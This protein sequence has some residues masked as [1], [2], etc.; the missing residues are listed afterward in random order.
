M[1]FSLALFS[2]A[3]SEAIAQTIPLKTLAAGVGRYFG[4]EIGQ[5]ALSDTNLTALT[6]AQC[7]VTTPENEMKWDATEP[8]QGVFTFTAGDAIV[9]FAEANGISVRGHNLVWSS[10]LPSCKQYFTRVTSTNWTNATLI[11]AMTNHITNVVTHYKGK[12]I[13]WD[14]VNEPF[15][16]DG[17]YVSDVFYNTIGPEYIPIALQAAR[18]ADPTVKLFIN[19]YNLDY[20][21]AKLT[22]MVN[23]VTSLHARGIPIDGIG[24]ESHLIVGNVS[25]SGYASTIAQMAAA[26]PGVLVAITEL[27]IRMPTPATTANLN[28]QETDYYSVVSACVQYSA[29]IGVETWGI[30]DK[31]SWIPS[32][33][34]GYGAALPYD[35]NFVPK[36]A[37]TG[38]V[39]GFGSVSATSS[40]TTTTTTTTA[41]TKT[42]TT[43]TTTTTTATTTKTTTVIT[44]TTTSPTTTTTTTTT[45]NP[46]TTTTTTITTAPTT[47]TATTGGSCSVKWGQCGGILWTGPTC[48]IAS[49]CTPQAGNPYYSQCL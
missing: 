24:S 10:Q 8:T 41:T 21:S 33:F 25:P 23:L 31:Y 34:S 44:T 26:F 29:C 27:D 47:T 45:K 5:E 14:V 48:C 9:S 17:S 19:D 35:A 42:T 36:P 4:C 28:Q 49:T 22:A 32:T 15:N 3:I 20:S 1:K 18:A 39:N 30:S 46:T 38:I 2:F 43:T 6:A 37:V 12:V 11:A 40:T 7:S 16:G 13:H